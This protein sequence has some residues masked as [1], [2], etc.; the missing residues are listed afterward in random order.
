MITFGCTIIQLSGV[1]C[2]PTYL[3]KCFT[4]HCCCSDVRELSFDVNLTCLGGRMVAGG[5]DM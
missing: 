5:V 1:S 4:V 2:V 3:T